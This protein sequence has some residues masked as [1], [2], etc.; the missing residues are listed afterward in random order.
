MLRQ[1]RRLRAVLNLILAHHWPTRKEYLESRFRVCISNISYSRTRGSSLE[2]KQRV[3]SPIVLT[4]M[5]QRNSLTVSCCTKL[6]AFR[7]SFTIECNT[8]PTVKYAFKLLHSINV[9]T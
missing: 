1:S 8:Y 3:Q 7:D 9:R 4:S 6:L 2:T 5:T